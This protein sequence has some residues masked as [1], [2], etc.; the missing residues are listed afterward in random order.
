MVNT[1]I[2]QEIRD[3]MKK[4]D[5]TIR[6]KLQLQKQ[7][8]DKNEDATLASSSVELYKTYIKRCYADVLRGSNKTGKNILPEAFKKKSN[9][10]RIMEYVSNF[11]PKVKANFFSALY[12]YTGDNEYQNAAV[13]AAKFSTQEKEKQEATEKEQENW[14]ETEAF[15]MTMAYHKKEAEEIM[16]NKAE[17]EKYDMKELQTIQNW[18]ILVLYS[19][20][21]FPVRR[22]ADFVHMKIRG[23]IDRSIHNEIDGNRFIF[24]NFKTS[25]YQPNKRQVGTIT[26]P[27]K[28]ILDKWIKINPY[29]YLLVNSKGMK[30]NATTLYQRLTKLFQKDSSVNMIRKMILTENYA[31]AFKEHLDKKKESNEAIEELA[32]VMKEGGSSIRNATSYIKNN[33]EKK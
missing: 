31:E 19:N 33:I 10:A 8:N 14:L 5:D 1:D 7:I 22:S 9:K 3:E 6:V 27:L 12:A 16:K 4:Y 17:N 13:K 26:R 29:E 28:R 11:K 23:D 18:I 21:Y 30:L 2:P 24:N 15:E 32:R 20:K 25:K